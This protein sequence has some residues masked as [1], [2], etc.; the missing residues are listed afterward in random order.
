MDG[1]KTRRTSLF[2]L[3]LLKSIFKTLDFSDLCDG[4]WWV[5]K[6]IIMKQAFSAFPYIHTYRN[7]Y[8]NISVD[9]DD[10]VGERC[11]AVVESYTESILTTCSNTQLPPRDGQSS[12]LISTSIVSSISAFFFA[13]NKSSKTVLRWS[14]FALVWIV[15]WSTCSS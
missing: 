4:G 11:G 8:I 1:I 14:N 15:L 7:Q 13:V 9:K 10:C 3:L 12:Q 2:Y 5:N 6:L